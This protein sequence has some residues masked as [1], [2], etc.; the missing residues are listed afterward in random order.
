MFVGVMRIALQ[1]P[2]A[3]SLKDKRRVVLS[4][5]ERVIGRMKVSVAEIAA[6]DDPRRAILG[7]AV[8]SNDAAVC[9][10]VLAD[11]AN[12]AGTLPDAVLADRRTEILPFGEGGASIQG[13]LLAEDTI[14]DD[15]VTISHDDDPDLEGE[16]QWKA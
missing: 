10:H 3:R 2:G 7:V 1:V 5:K 12:A 9:D 13:G 8:V 6:L 14:A 15:E 4:F 11:V 16:Q